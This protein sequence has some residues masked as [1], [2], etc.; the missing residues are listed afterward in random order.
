[1]TIISKNAIILKSKEGFSQREIGKFFNIPRAS[2]QYMLNNGSKQ[3]QKRGPK[4]KI[5]KLD[6]RHIR[7]ALDESRISRKK[8]A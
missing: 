2:V 5:S 8:W 6:K 1:M 7:S 4:T 3:L